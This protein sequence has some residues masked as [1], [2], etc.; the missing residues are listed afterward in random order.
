MR[1]KVQDKKDVKSRIRTV[2]CLFPKRIEDTVYWLE[3]VKIYEEKVEY[4]FWDDY[5]NR[6]TYFEWEAKYVI[7]EVTI[8]P[9]WKS[10][11]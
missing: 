7:E 6:N 5:G 1:W 8:E 2:F 4:E 11:N 3:K 10:Q 9:E